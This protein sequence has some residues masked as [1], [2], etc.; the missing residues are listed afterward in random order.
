[1]SLVNAIGITPEPKMIAI[2]EII[3]DITKILFYY[4]TYI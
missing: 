1:M 4:Y 3:V 2:N